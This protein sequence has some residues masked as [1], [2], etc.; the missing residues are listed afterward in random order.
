[1]SILKRTPSSSTSSTVQ[2]S[3][4]HAH[5]IL[6]PAAGP[7]DFHRQLKKAVE[8]LRTN[9]WS[10]TLLETKEKG[11]ATHLARQAAEA[12]S[13]VAIAV[14]GDGTINEVVNGLAGSDTA[15]AII[16]AGTANVYAADIGIPIWN[17]LRP[18]AVRLAAE[19]IHT[20]QRERID[21]GRIE[22]ANGERRYFFMWC[23]VGLDAAISQEIHTEDTRRL[24]MAA[25]VIAGVMVA[26]NFM[27]TRGN[28]WVDN[29][30]G[31]KRVLWAVISNGQ[32]YGRLWRIAPHAKMNDGMLDLTVFEGYGVL[33]TVRHL[34]GL[35]LGQ[36]ARDPAVHF[37][38]G[39][40]FH[41]ET[42]KPLPVHV[43][44][45]PI[46]TTPVQITVEP[47]VLKVVLPHK[48]PE[49]LLLRGSG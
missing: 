13:D 25:W 15:L 42:R 29:Q 49:H 2:H 35:T 14:G 23:G 47:H 46:G 8:Y 5:L 24:G 28:V 17:P 18:N 38:R 43:D 6:N 9:G 45:E 11:D 27:G 31:R 33:S 37:Y 39:R 19:I 7:R 22:L 44:A 20:G 26:L 41:I 1:L 34:A 36:Y 48:Y 4:L 40:S 10:V 12:G 32:L 30:V 16:P 21:L 3:G